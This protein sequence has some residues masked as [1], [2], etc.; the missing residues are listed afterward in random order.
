M[1]FKILVGKND[2]L[3]KEELDKWLTG[4]LDCSVI[5]NILNLQC[6]LIAPFFSEQ[7]TVI[8]KGFDF[9]KESEQ[10]IL[11]YIKILPTSTNLIIVFDTLRK[12]N[13][14]YKLAKEKGCLKLFEDSTP[15]E[16]KAFIDKWSK[17]FNIKWENK[18]IYETFVF[19][20]GNNFANIHQELKKLENKTIGEIDLDSV[21]KHREM[22]VFDLL[23][24]IVNKDFKNFFICAEYYIKEGQDPIFLVTLL[25]KQFRQMIII[26]DCERSKSL[27]D[28]LGLSPFVLKLISKQATKFNMAQLMKMYIELDNLLYNLKTKNISFRPIYI[29]D[30]FAKVL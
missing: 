6:C 12:D 13:S 26:K 10:R 30:I 15:Q 25:L 14:I 17:S 8:L 2:F 20:V 11:N 4:N 23:N 24:F 7:K 16:I 1:T 22:I 9:N 18:E 21:S 3:I 5:D 28:S 19:L 27:A 29:S